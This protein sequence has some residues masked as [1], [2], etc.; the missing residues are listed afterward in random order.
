STHW[1]TVAAARAGIGALVA[2]AFAV[3]RKAPLVPRARGLSWARSLLGTAA[4]LTTFYAVGSDELALGDAATLFATAPLFIAMLSPWVLGE[5]TDRALWLVLLV[6][7]GGA[8]IIA[9]PHLAFGSL[10]AAAALGAAVFSALAMMF[11]RKM[12]SRAGREAPESTEAIALHFGVVAF[13]VFLGINLFCFRAPTGEGWLW[14]GATGLSGGLAQLAMT[15][16]YALTEAT[17]LGALSYLG[18]VLSLVGSFLV[19][20]ERPTPLQVLGSLLVIGAG[21]ALAWLSARSI[22]APMVVKNSV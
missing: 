21:T 19:L 3:V 11:L 7:F 16:A 20:G 15:Q 6:A 5:P 1:S 18:T 4:M 2:L 8:A 13:L 12:R 14:L 22:S 10:P 9:G 17:R